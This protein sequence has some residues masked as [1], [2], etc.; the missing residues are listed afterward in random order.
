[1]QRRNGLFAGEDVPGGHVLGIR[2][3]VRNG[4]EHRERDPQAL[5]RPLSARR[6]FC[7]SS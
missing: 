2:S 1:M 6:R 5:A 3:V 4:R 7:M